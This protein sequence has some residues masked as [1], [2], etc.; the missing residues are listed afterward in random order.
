MSLNQSNC[1][2]VVLANSIKKGHRCVAGKCLETNEWIRPV[3]TPQGGEL[4]RLQASARN[5]YGVYPVKTLQKVNMSFSRKSPLVNQP[6]N[7]LIDGTEWQ[8]C[9]TISENQLSQFLDYPNNLWGLGD[10]VGYREIQDRAK[11]VDQSLYLVQVESLMLYYADSGTKRRATFTYNGYDYDLAATSPN[12]DDV[13]HEQ[14]DLM[15]ILCISLGECFY[16]NCFKIVAAI[17]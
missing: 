16:N 14:D 9:Y 12:F 7:R 13:V 2:M 8:Q 4:T 5:P 11:S 1:T 10:R 3:A 17:Y 6:E 15:G